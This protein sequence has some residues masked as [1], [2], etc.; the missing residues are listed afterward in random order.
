MPFLLVKFPSIHSM[1]LLYMHLN[2]YSISYFRA[3]TH[4]CILIV[5]NANI[6]KHWLHRIENR[7]RFITNAESPNYF[8]HA[9]HILNHFCF[10]YKVKAFSFFIS[11]FLAFYYIFTYNVSTESEFRTAVQLLIVSL[12]CFHMS[13]SLLIFGMQFICKKLI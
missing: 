2:L 9:V 11:K 13:R 5:N 12:E 6:S 8:S 4:Y 10:I 3:S 7:M 1:V